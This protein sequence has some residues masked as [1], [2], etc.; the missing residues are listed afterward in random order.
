M[1]VLAS[2]TLGVVIMGLFAVQGCFVLLSPGSLRL[3]KPSGGVVSWIYNGLNLSATLLFTPLAALTLIRGWS[4]PGDWIGFDLGSLPLHDTLGWI[5]LVSYGLGM[6][7][8][9]WSRV[10]LGRSFRLG[11]L[12][13]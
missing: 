10:V 3:Q 1:F 7:L 2:K 6:A 12:L 9:C 5:G 4:A 8:M 11:E 13:T